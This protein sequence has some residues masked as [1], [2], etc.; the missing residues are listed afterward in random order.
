VKHDREPVLGEL[1]ATQIQ[2]L[3]SYRGLLEE[4]GARTG[5]TGPTEGPLLWERHV[6]DSLRARPCL[7]DATSPV[8]DLGSGA[9]LPGIPL[10]I[11]R[12]DLAFLLV[13][14][15]RRRVAF[16]ELAAERLGLRNI[17]IRPSRAEA[18]QL[19]AGVCVARAFAPPV[20]TWRVA[21][22]LLNQR[23]YLLYYAG[24]SWRLSFEDQLA[25]AGAVAR[26][27]VAAESPWQG[28]IVSIRARVASP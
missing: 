11:A 21:S 1:T 17:E 12:P 20:R 5:V 9:G 8:V 10:A 15:Q 23:G 18:V 4:F 2:R 25:E 27:C 24:R 16:L 13:E 26:V 3:H 19:R 14:P 7:I 28:P 22:R 6:L